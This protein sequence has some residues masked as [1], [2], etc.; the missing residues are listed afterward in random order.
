MNRARAFS[1]L[2]TGLLGL[3]MIFCLWQAVVLWQSMQQK[4]TIEP[5]YYRLSNDALKKTPQRD[6]STL[7]RLFT[8]AP[9]AI[10]PPEPVAAIVPAVTFPE[11]ELLGTIVNSNPDKSLAIFVIDGQQKL[12][13]RGEHIGD[14]QVKLGTI[15]DERVTVYLNGEQKNLTIVPRYGQHPPAAVQEQAPP[16]ANPDNLQTLQQALAEN[17]SAIVEYVRFNPEFKDGKLSAYRI[18]PGKNV[19][20]FRQ[21]GLEQND[22][23]Y[24]ISSADFYIEMSDSNALLSLWPKM[25]QIDSFKLHLTRNEQQHEVV[26]ALR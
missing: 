10:L 12:F 6:L 18:S 15:K 16:P 20:L 5:V 3:G 2:T 1:L 21:L 8:Q 26:I 9:Q 13:G 11:L 25:Q 7:Q 14:S 24:A 19:N 4:P 22:L 23:V 17:P